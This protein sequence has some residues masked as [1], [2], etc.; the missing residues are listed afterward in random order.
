DEIDAF[1]F[2]DNRL[3]I[4]LF[5]KAVKGSYILMSATPPKDIVTDFKNNHL[6]ILALHTRYHR[7]PLPEP[8]NVIRIGY[9][10]ILYLIKMIKRYQ[11]FKKPVLVFAPTIAEAEE[12]F[13]LLK[14]FLKR[15][16]FVHSKCLNRKEI[17]TDFKKHKYDYL[18]TTSV[19]ERGVTI[20]DVQV[21]IYHADDSMYQSGV[22][23]QIAGRVGRKIDAPTGDVIFL[24]NKVTSSMKEAINAIK[25][26]NT[27][28]TR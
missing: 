11:K 14:I 5:K 4:N 25:L 3:L 12:V 20:K 10:K 6:P 24:A 18:L 2:K 8:I 15:G 22:L 27:Y 19:L 17:I 21:I 28:L 13:C 23:I 1:P 16:N 7:H 26:D 9:L